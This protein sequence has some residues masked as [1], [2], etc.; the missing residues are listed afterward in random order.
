MND[1]HI[2]SYSNVD[3][4]WHTLS[5][6]GFLQKSFAKGAWAMLRA[7]YNHKHR[8]RLVKGMDKNVLEL[9]KEMGL[10]EVGV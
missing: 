4:K 5:G 10:Q 9:V 3:N 1:W 8:H 2:Q 7:F 6:F